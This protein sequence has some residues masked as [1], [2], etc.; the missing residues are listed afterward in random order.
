MGSLCDT[1]NGIPWAV[2][3]SSGAALV[4]CGVLTDTARSQRRVDTSGKMGAPERP[5][6]RRLPAL[7]AGVRETRV[8]P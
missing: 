8:G 2:R 5:R 3:E 7:L 4:P 1:D 6:E